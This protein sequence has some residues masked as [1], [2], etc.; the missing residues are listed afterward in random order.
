[1]TSMRAVAPFADLIT[2][3]RPA[4]SSAT[5]AKNESTTSTRMNGTIADTDECEE[6][7]IPGSYCPLAPTTR[8][9]D[10]TWSWVGTSPRAC[11]PLAGDEQNFVAIDFDLGPS[12]RVGQVINT[13]RAM[14]RHVIAPTFSGFLDFVARQYVEG[15]VVRSDTDE[16]WLQLAWDGGDLLTGLRPLLGLPASYEP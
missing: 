8:L 11:V 13:G 6:L 5:K 7:G 12:G 9:A 4:T 2:G 16:R 1:M 14:M 15:R 3:E 10:T